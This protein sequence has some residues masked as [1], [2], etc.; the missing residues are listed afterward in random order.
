M[1]QRYSARQKTVFKILGAVA[2]LGLVIL[3]NRVPALKE[4]TA[5]RLLFGVSALNFTLRATI[6]LALGAMSGIL[7]ERTGIIN[8]GIEGMMLAGAF[9][10]FVA[11]VATNGWPLYASLAVGVLAAL[12]VGGLMGLLHG[13]F[14]IRYRMDQI[15]SGTVLIIL[16]SG[17]TAYLFDR[18]AIAVGK[19]SAIRIPLLADI[20]V[21]G[22]ILFKNPPL[23][24][25]ALLLVV[26]LHVTLFHTR[27]GLRTRACG[28]HPR[29][30]DTVGI[31]VNKYRYFNTMLGGAV[32]GLAGG[33]LVLEAVGQF[34]EG[35]TAG[36]GFIAL[37]AMI[38]GNWNAVRR[39]R[40]SRA[41]RLYPGA[42]KRTSA[43]R[44]HQYPAAVRGDVAL[45]GDDRCRFRFRGPCAAPR[46]GRQ[47]LRD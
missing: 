7:C 43:G 14:S 22:D 11:K 2:L 9:A 37:A 24:Y 25:L 27:W 10:A 32:A 21:I 12:L 45:C 20:P 6:P 15:I 13:T 4:I 29:A 3:V 33:F 47:V 16:A 41:V 30:A 19:F 42:A 5:L 40:C 17:L 26:V 18:N 1:K 38:F 28:E 8:I 44:L 23:T 31:N 39:T 36:R 35:M 34:Q 46:R